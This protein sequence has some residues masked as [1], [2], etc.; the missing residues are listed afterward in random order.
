MKLSV[1]VC[2]NVPWYKLTPPSAVQGGSRIN[3]T[4]LAAPLLPMPIMPGIITTCK[5]FEFIGKDMSI[6][7]LVKEN[8]ITTEQ[9]FGFNTNVNKTQPPNIFLNYWVCVG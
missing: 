8:N 1:P 7:G 9:F 2:I 5:T 4:G 3:V 6:E